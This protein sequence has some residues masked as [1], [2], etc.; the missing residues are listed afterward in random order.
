M[1]MQPIVNAMPSQLRKSSLVKVRNRLSWA[2]WRPI[3]ALPMKVTA[4]HL[5]QKIEEAASSYFSNSMIFSS[6]DVETERFV[7]FR[8]QS[9]AVSFYFERRK[10]GEMERVDMGS[11]AVETIQERDEKVAFQCRMNILP[12]GYEKEFFVLLPADREAYAE[13]MNFIDRMKVQ[14]ERNAQ[15]YL[16]DLEMDELGTSM[17]SSSGGS[18]GGGGSSAYAFMQD[19]EYEGLTPEE[20]EAVTGVRPGAPSKSPKTAGDALSMDEIAALTGGG[21]ED[22]DGGGL[23]QEEIEALSAAHSEEAE[24]ETQSLSEDQIAAMLGGFGLGGDDSSDSKDESDSKPAPSPQ[25]R[26]KGK[27]M[28]EE[29][30]LDASAE[31]IL[32]QLMGTSNKEK[33]KSPKKDEPLEASAEDIFAQMMGS[34]SSSAGKSAGKASSAGSP[35]EE[36]A[37]MS[38]EDILAQLMGGSGANEAEEISEELDTAANEAKGK[39]GVKGSKGTTASQDE[40]SLEMSAEDIWKQISGGA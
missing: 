23:S 14:W 35:T 18:G 13:Y 3:K 36:T 4:F 21:F 19:D 8:R 20:I 39:G 5:I 40:D 10:D 30:P 16:P 32:A 31:D 27:P 37:D 22:D 11:L 25:P 1:D 33:A 2:I 26:S 38:A 9:A 24:T 17:G 15:H 7:N 6:Q 34:G 12:G 29:E 28:P